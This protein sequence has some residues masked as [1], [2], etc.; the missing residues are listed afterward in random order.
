L[1]NR[2]RPP[3]QFEAVFKGKLVEEPRGQQD[4][5]HIAIQRSQN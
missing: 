5:L 2:R 3:E 4:V 1:R